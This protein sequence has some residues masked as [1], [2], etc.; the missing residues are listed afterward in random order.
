MESQAQKKSP[1]SRFLWLSVSALLL[2]WLALS[3]VRFGTE[4]GQAAASGDSFWT[5]SLSLKIHGGDKGA[6]VKLAIPSDTVHLQL[7]GQDLTHAGWRQ[8]FVRDSKTERVRQ[9]KFI[10]LDE[11]A[12][13]VQA[14]YSIHASAIPH[15]RSPANAKLSD[16]KREHYLAS[17]PLL[18]L[19][20]SS[21]EREAE[22]LGLGSAS[23]EELLA[24]IYSR[25][26][27]LLPQAAGAPRSVDEVIESGRA[28]GLERALVMVSLCRSQEIP[29]RLVTGL[30]L[31]EVTKAKLRHWVEVY[32]DEQSWLFFDPQAGYQR[33][34]PPL[35]LPL[36]KDRS[37]LVEVQGAEG[38]EL[39]L[40]L[41]RV[42]ELF[43]SH[44]HDNTE[45]WQVLDLERLPLD[46]R[47]T[48]ATLLLL[49]L[50]VLASTLF[51]ELT[52]VRSFGTFTPTLFAL[53]V[54]YTDWLTAVISLSLVLLFGIA[55]R[56]SMPVKIRRAPRLTIVFALVALGVSGSVSVMDLMGWNHDGQVVLLPIVILATLVDRIYTTIDD[57]GVTSAVVRLGWTLLL[58]M[59]CLPIVRFQALGHYLVAHPEYHLLTLALVLVI[60]SY[61]G[62]RLVDVRGFA[63]LGWPPARKRETKAAVQETA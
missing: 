63:W 20:N 42:D 25:A 28:T 2:I 51:R 43:D 27:Q 52:G 34:L 39:E 53:A 44:A 56:S 41:S 17:D 59:L 62:R 1:H 14:E 4:T 10:A 21:L 16:T 46:V 3:L 31:K 11:R 9:L 12:S 57:E 61:K 36:A 40:G 15:L 49:P 60:S 29:A 54:S 23:R 38:Y 33:E 35:Y 26:R 32:D 18:A 47:I 30:V 6:I 48:L 19:S 24:R 50:G 5:V 22:A 55:G 37:E 58:A 45:W 8:S 13:V 7:V